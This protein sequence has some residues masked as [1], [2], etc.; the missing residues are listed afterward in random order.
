MAAVEVAK[1]FG[2]LS[3]IKKD[4]SESQKFP[5]VERRYLFGRCMSLPQISRRCQAAAIFTQQLEGRVGTTRFFARGH[6]AS[7]WG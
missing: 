6:F 4:G 7:G 2:G 5:L 1:A 3:L